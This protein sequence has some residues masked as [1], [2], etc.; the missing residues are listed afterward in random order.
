MENNP[1]FERTEKFIRFLDKELAAR[2]WTDYQLAKRA[3]ISPSVISRARTGTLPKWE[4]SERI[5]HAF[6]IPVETVFRMAALLPPLSIDSEKMGLL[7]YYFA[8]L[9]EE[10][11]EEVLDFVQ[12]KLR[13]KEARN[14]ARERKT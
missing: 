2:G 5:A 6:Q 10:E 7:S 11:Q 12:A 14:K 1:L 13:R 4:A 8:K 9:D 3:G